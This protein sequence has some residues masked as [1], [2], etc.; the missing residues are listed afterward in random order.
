MPK[1]TLHTDGDELQL[2]DVLDSIEHRCKIKRILVKPFFDDASKNQNSAMRVNHVTPNQFKQALKNH[3][4]PDCS[5]EDVD[6]IIAKF[7]DEGGLVNYSS[8]AS[9]VD[10]SGMHYDPYTLEPS[11]V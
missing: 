7:S 10:P 5:A 11:E 4:A 1:K 8:F 2:N 9:R 3:I 6:L